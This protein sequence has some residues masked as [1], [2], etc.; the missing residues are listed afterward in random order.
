MICKE[1]A[2]LWRGKKFWLLTMTAWSPPCI[3]WRYVDISSIVN[4]FQLLIRGQTAAIL[5]ITWGTNK[6]VSRHKNNSFPEEGSCCW[7][8]FTI[9]LPLKTHCLASARKQTLR[10]SYDYLV[11]SSSTDQ[12]FI[13][14]PL[15][16]SFLKACLHWRF[17]PVTFMVIL[18][19]VK[20]IK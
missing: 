20:N 11:Y 10:S 8:I 19:I 16:S 15:I 4:V 17:L 6:A 5:S 18:I 1:K 9:W 2:L 12:L 7:F 13:K 3:T 14:E